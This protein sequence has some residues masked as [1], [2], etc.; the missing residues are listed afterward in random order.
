MRAL[1][2]ALLCAVPM[3]ACAGYAP[4]PQPPP[5]ALS[6]NVWRLSALASDQ[7]VARLRALRRAARLTLQ[8]G[9][10]WF[11]VLDREHGSEGESWDFQSGSADADD[12]LSDPGPAAVAT[13]EFEVGRGPSPGGRDVYDARQV[14]AGARTGPR[15]RADRRASPV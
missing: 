7:P 9:G 3:A 13:L 1:A 12:L 10:D 4:P 2:A 11:R 14:D 5:L 8:Q 15:R 6:P